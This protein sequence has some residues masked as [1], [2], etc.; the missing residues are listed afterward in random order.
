V[1]GDRIEHGSVVPPEALAPLR[2]L[3]L[4]VV[5]QPNFVAERG[6]EYL[7]EVE[8]ADR[9]WL[10]RV[11]GLLRAGVSTAAG[12]DAPFG[13]PDPW[14]AMAAAVSRRTVHGSV[15]GAAER[16]SPERALALFTGPLDRPGRPLRVSA[17][18]PADLCL[19]AVPWRE[20]RSQLSSGLVAATIR[21]G[22]VI[23]Q[24]AETGATPAGPP[25]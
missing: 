18:G 17:G 21:A 20:A 7:E 12:T 4:T 10:Y 19:L 5:T 25:P 2:R 16:V 15:L 3:G 9:P 14:K 22:R 24:R 11:A 6:D 13:G 8:A 1:P 23:Y